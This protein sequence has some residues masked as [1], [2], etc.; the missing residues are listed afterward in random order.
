MNT[1][2]NDK[3]AR[4]QGA[5]T[6]TRVADSGTRLI[7]AEL[8]SA[9]S[10]AAAARNGSPAAAPLSVVT[11]LAD[12][13]G[14]FFARVLAFP[15]RATQR[16]AL[17]KVMHETRLALMNHRREAIE[18]ESRAIWESSSFKVVAVMAEYLAQHLRG[19][20]QERYDHIMQSSEEAAELL[21]HHLEKIEASSLPDLVKERLLKQALEQYDITLE[22]ITEDQLHLR[23][24]NRS[25]N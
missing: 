13:Q 11:Q 9:S 20:E 25:G 12:D 14:G 19:I 24:A 1:T 6:S 4:I 18:R 17:S 21:T 2:L 5:R 16:E 7:E 23:Y 10:A 3:L 22:R 15:F 8:L